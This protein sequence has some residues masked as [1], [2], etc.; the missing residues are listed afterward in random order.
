MTKGSNVTVNAVLPGPT[1]SEGAGTFVK[2][3]ATQ[4]N[5]TVE[6]MEKEFFK[7][8]RPTSILQRFITTEEIANM[9]AYIASDLSVATNGAAIRADGGL[10]KSPF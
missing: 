2:D 4:K 9:V 6:A 10:V 5:I 3:M 8:A 1:F 7:T